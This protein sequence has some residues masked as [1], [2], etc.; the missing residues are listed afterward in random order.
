MRFSQISVSKPFTHVPCRHWCDQSKQGVSF[1]LGIQHWHNHHCH[2][3][4]SRQPQR[5][6]SRCMQGTDAREMKDGMK[7][8]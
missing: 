8:S 2:P 4:S 1:N 7:D 5:E 6:A 3:R